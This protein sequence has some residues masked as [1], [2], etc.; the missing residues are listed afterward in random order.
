MNVI[1]HGTHQPVAV[2]DIF[3]C[4]GHIEGGNTNNYNFISDCTTGMVDQF[5]QRKESFDLI[6]FGSVK[7]VLV[8][9]EILDIDL[10][11]LTNIYAPCMVVTHASVI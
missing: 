1:P 9:G 10:P 2:Y 8:A 5:D 6:N 3:Y 4:T 11:N 7:V